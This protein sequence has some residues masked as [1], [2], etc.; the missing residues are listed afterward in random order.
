MILTAVRSSCGTTATE[1]VASASVV[2]S[3]YCNQETT[4]A[5]PSPSSGAVSKY[6]TDLSAFSDLGPCAGSALS[7]VVQHLTGE[8][9]PSGASALESCACTKDQISLAVSGSLSYYVTYSC[10]ST[11]SED[12]A[13]AQAVFAGY[14]GLGAGISSFPSPSALA[15]AVTYHVT[16]L[17]IYSSL[18]KCA[19]SA[20]SYPILAQTNRDCPSN[21]RSL[22]SCICVKDGNL[23]A[24]S[25]GI[26]SSV[27]YNCGSTASADI[28]SALAVLDYYCSAG[29]GL[30]TPAGVTASGMS[31]GKTLFTPT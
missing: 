26:T 11:H 13:S 28:T 14:C 1:D 27:K 29:K 24:A 4:V 17:P 23:D 12:I 6:I 2:F 8:K 15:G 25:S 22:V 20:V 21:P 3:A 7:Y 31:T 10:G 30:V 5:V 9:C 19:Q 18:A 16:D